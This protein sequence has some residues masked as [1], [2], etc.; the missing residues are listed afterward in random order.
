MKQK[1]PSESKSEVPALGAIPIQ[2]GAGY[3]NQKCLNS[4]SKLYYI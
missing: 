1:K 3:L 2:N 4:F